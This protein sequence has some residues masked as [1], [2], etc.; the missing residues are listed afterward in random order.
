MKCKCGKDNSKIL[1]G[2]PSYDGYTYWRQHKCKE[3]GEKWFTQDVPDD[4]PFSFYAAK[5]E[6]AHAS[7]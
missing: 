4:P 6:H 2:V 5:R 7:S 1:A 3:C